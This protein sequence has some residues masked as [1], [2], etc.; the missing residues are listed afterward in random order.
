MGAF[1]TK[2]AFK[3]PFTSRAPQIFWSFSAHTHTLEGPQSLHAGWKEC[4]SHILQNVDIWLLLCPFLLPH[5][6]CF[7]LITGITFWRWASTCRCS[8]ASLWTSSGKWVW[9]EKPFH[10][11]HL[12]KKTWQQHLRVCFLWMISYLVPGTWTSSQ[13]VKSKEKDVV[14]FSPTGI[15][16]SPT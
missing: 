6:H 12:K 3:G 10:R 14:S 9:K 5:S 8:C 15:F 4:C 1:R 7:Q 16:P 13:A 11:H 2:G